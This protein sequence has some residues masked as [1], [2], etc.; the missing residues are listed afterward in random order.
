MLTL[1]HLTRR[2]GSLTAVNDVSLRLP[3]GARHAVIGPN[4]AGKTT[5]LNLIA[6]TER[7]DGGTILLADPDRPGGSGQLGRAGRAGLT[8]RAGKAGGIDLTRTEAARRSRLGIARSY[9]QPTVI[10]EL[11]ALDNAML[12]GWRHHRAGWTAWRRPARRRQMRDIAMRRL[13]AV[14][15]ADQAEHPAGALSHGQRRML[16]LAAALVGE[17]RLLLLDEP[18]AGLTDRDIGR[19]VDVLRD[20]PAD[21]ALLLVEHHIEVVTELADNVTVL[22]SGSV[23]VSGGTQEALSDPEVREVYLD[24]VPTS[25]AESATGAGPANGADTPP[26]ATERG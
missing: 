8:G 22:A 12:A 19:L 2:Y 11:T 26:S 20:I 5:L 14:G 10:T 1:S 3:V 18:A 4:G 25:V 17:P 23:L 16:D 24:T 6:G 13:E 15:L 7:P 9:Q 21:V